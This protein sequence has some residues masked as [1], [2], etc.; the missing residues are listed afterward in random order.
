MQPDQQSNYWPRN[1]DEVG[2]DKTPEPPVVPEIPELPPVATETYTPES[3]D[4]DA[5]PVT[6]VDAEEDD[7]QE[8][9]TNED[10]VHWSATEYIHEEKSPLWFVLF[11]IVALALIATDIFVWKSYTFSALVFVMALAVIILSRRPPRTIDYTLSGDQGLYVGE[12]LY[13]FSEF[14]SFGLIDDRGNN[15]IMLMPVKRLATGVF[16]Y[17][18]E[19]VGEEIVDI[20]GARLPMEHLKLDIIDIVVRKLRL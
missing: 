2:Q 15:S 4:D 9:G 16:V 3:I 5:T 13:H 14:K 10:A 6:D 8:P 18:P 12:K 11:G 1:P 7:S 17:F 19:E 20:L